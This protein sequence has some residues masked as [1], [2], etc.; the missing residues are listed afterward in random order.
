MEN[1]VKVTDIRDYKAV[2]IGFLRE[3]CSTM[4]CILKALTV[5][6]CVNTVIWESLSRSPSFLAPSPFW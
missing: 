2:W 3:R 5:K 4:K 1:G 6:M